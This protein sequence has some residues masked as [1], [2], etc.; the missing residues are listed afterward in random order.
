MPTEQG[1]PSGRSPPR[2]GGIAKPPRPK[3]PI[4][5]QCKRRMTIKRVTPILFASG[6]DDV[7]YGCD[8]CGTETKRT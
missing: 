1:P 5:P 4:C 2:F 3:N 6:M 7:V 8:D